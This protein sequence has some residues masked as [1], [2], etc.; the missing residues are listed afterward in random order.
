MSAGKTITEPPSRPPGRP[1][2]PEADRAI[3]DAAIDLFID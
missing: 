1:R 2:S 3:L